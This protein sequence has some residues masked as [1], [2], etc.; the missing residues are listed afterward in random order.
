MFQLIMKLIILSFLLVFELINSQVDTKIKIVD[1]EDNKP[2]YHA[3][4][5]FDNESYYTNEDGFVIIPNSASNIEVVAN[6]YN[7]KKL[8]KVETMIKMTP[9]YNSI[10]EVIIHQI[11]IKK[12]FKDVLDNYKKRY[13]TEESLYKITYKQKNVDDGK[14]SFLLIGEGKLWTKSNM[15][16]YK[17][18]HNR[19]FDDFLKLQLDD[20]KYFKNTIRDGEV[21]KGISLN[22]SRDFIG[23][24]FFNYELNRVNGYF[25]VKNAKYSGRLISDNNNE[26]TISFNV[27]SSELNVKGLIIYHKA[28][29]AIK[30]YELHYDQTNYPS[31]KRII[32]GH[33]YE[34]KV[35]NGVVYFDF[36]KN[37]GVYTPSLAGTKGFSFCSWDGEKHKN[38]FTRDIVFNKVFDIINMDNFKG[39]DLNKRIWENVKNIANED[40]Q[41]IVLTRDEKEFLDEKEYEK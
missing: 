39:I 16:N 8:L 26:Q 11:D 21:C 2:I 29:K 40:N 33:E 25:K 27:D 14:V 32:N 17:S 41:S 13:N 24:I 19:E 28:D 35:G 31:V 6:S 38:T 15:Y 36:H 37:G 1:E 22:V 5:S 34:H 23:N 18:A 10:D 30:Y 12:I 3:R 7:S 4:I 20:I 9:I